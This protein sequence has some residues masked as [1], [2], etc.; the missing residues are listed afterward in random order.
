M[1]ITMTMMTMKAVVTT[2]ALMGPTITTITIMIII[3]GL[4]TIVVILTEIMI[5]A[6]ETIS[7]TSKVSMI[8]FIPY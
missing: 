8:C 1:T 7:T 4:R 2:M 6:G 3:I 5:T